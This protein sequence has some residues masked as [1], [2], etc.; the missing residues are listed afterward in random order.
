MRCTWPTDSWLGISSST[1][2]G[3]CFL[4]LSSSDLTSSRV[5]SSPATFLSTSVTCVI[6]TEA[7]SI[8]V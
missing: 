1:T 2:A 4:W 7:A 5:S 3:L 6:S 8:T